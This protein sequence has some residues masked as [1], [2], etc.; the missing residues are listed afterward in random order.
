MPEQ[1]GRN[2][3]A[4]SNAVFPDVAEAD[5]YAATVVWVNEAGIV[6]NYRNSTFGASDFTTRE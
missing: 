2:P 3:A 4:E 6:S 1:A 5:W